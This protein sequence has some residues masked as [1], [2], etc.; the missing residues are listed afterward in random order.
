MKRQLCLVIALALLACML[1]ACSQAAVREPSAYI[2]NERMPLSGISLNGNITEVAVHKN[3]AFTLNDEGSIVRREIASGESAPVIMGSEALSIG[4]DSSILAVV[5]G[6]SII[7]YD[8]DGNELKNI[9]L[10]DTVK[11]AA[12][13]AVGDRYAAFVSSLES[14]DEIRLVNIDSG[15]I[16]TLSDEW[17]MGNANADLMYCYDFVK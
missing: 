8:Y 17:R 4:C 9:P 11:E 6:S 15:N 7:L 16:T 10:D 3:I 2:S 1:S 5:T 14:G 13:V 12:A